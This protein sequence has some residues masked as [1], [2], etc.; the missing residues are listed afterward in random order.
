MAVLNTGGDLVDIESLVGASCITLS[1]VLSNKF[2]PITLSRIFDRKNKG[3]AVVTCCELSTL[4][5]AFHSIT[6]N[7]KLSCCGPA[8]NLILSE[9]EKSRSSVLKKTPSS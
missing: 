6:S 8:E 7:P 9:K 3:S 2:A 5:L 4:R 1:W